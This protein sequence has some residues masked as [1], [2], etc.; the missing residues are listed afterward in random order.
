MT[1]CGVLSLS[2]VTSHTPSKVLCVY[3][4]DRFPT[5][6]SGPSSFSNRSGSTPSQKMSVLRIGPGRTETEPRLSI[7]GDIGA[8]VGIHFHILSGCLN[9]TRT[10]ADYLA[11]TGFSVSE[12]LKIKRCYSH[13]LPRSASVRT[14]VDLSIV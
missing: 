9:S 5:D 6:R 8:D 11:V 1:L 3:R 12:V 2:Q 14:G 13:A 7:P 10:R 4:S